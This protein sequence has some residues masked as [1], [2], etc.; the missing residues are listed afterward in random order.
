MDLAKK[1]KKWGA[2]DDP[3]CSLILMVWIALGSRLGSL[4]ST[5]LRCPWYWLHRHLLVPS[6]NSHLPSIF[7]SPRA[8]NWIKPLQTLQKERPF[9]LMEPEEKHAYQVK[10]NYGLPAAE[11][12]LF[13][14]TILHSLKTCYLLKYS[15]G[16]DGTHY[17]KSTGIQSAYLSSKT[18]PSLHHF[19]QWLRIETHVSILPTPDHE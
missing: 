11:S 1:K 14:H 3:I 10:T 13:E 8:H 19:K 2:S 5:L 6:G 9:H 15:A 4:H 12:E 7:K 16:Q 18:F 17:W